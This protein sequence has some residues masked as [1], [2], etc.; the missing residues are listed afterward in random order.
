MLVT[1][2]VKVLVDLF[3]ILISRML[4]EKGRDN[5]ARGEGQWVKVLEW[6][7]TEPSLPLGSCCLLPSFFATQVKQGGGWLTRL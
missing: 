6:A 1:A 5:R 3:I 2:K 4:R 7:Q